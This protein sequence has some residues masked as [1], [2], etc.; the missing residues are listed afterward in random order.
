[1][2]ELILKSKDWNDFKTRVSKL[3]NTKQIGDAFEI[4]IK[5]YLISSPTYNT[6]LKNVW[7][8][9]EVPTKTH[10]LLELKDIDLGIDLIAET[11]DDE[12][13]SVQAK[14][15]T[16]ETSSL[17]YRE[18]STFS[19]FSFN[20]CKN[21]SFGLVCTTTERLSKHLKGIDKISFLASD[22]WRNLNIEDF[23]LIKSH[24]QHKEIKLKP[25]KPRKHQKKAIKNAISHFNKDEQSRG[26]MIMPCASGKSLTSYWVRDKLGS[27]RTIIAVPSLS[28]MSQTID[29]WAREN[30]AN[31]KNIKWLAVASDETVAEAKKD[32]LAFFL[33]DFG[34]PVKTDIEYITDWLTKHKD[35][36][37]VV[38]TTYQSG[39][40]IAQASKNASISYDLGIMDEAHKTVGQKDKLFSYLLFDKNIQID[41]RLFM[42]ATERRYAGKQ[43]KILSMEDIDVY[44]DTFELL[45]FK[46]AVEYREPEI[47]CDYKVITIVVDQSEI[48]ELIQN[49]V[50]VE[51]DKLNFNKEIE[52]EMLA[53]A[54]A[55]RKAMKKHPI[56]HAVTFHGSIKKAEFFKDLQDSLS[57]NSKDFVKLETFHVNGKMNTS[58][59][60]RVLKEFG[61]S[62]Y[63]LITNARCLTE[64]I[65]VP[66]IDCILFADPK[67]S[68]VDIVQAVGR[69][70]R[71]AE[72][73]KYGYVVI[74]LLNR[75][76][77][78]EDTAFDDILMILRALASNDERIVEYFRAKFNKKRHTGGG[79]VEI[80]IDER[81]AQKIDIDKFMEAIETKCWKRL[82]KL[83]WRPFEEAREFVHSLKLQ[84]NSQWLKYC[85]GGK[86]PLDIPIKPRVTYRNDG[87]I[88]MGDWL[89][90]GRIAD[91]YKEYIPFFQSR[92]FVHT[93]NLKSESEWREY[94]KSGKKPDNIPAKPYRTYK[95]NWISMGDWLGT[96]RIADQYKSKL[97]L[98]YE[99]AKII[100]HSLKLKNQFDWESFCKTSDFPYNIPKSPAN[101]YKNSGWK[102]FGDWLGTGRI[103]TQN[104]KYLS[105][106]KAKKFVHK[107]GLKSSSEWRK[108]S[109]G[110]LNITKPPNIPSSPIKVYKNEWISWSDW[111]GHNFI[112]TFKR[113]YLSF[114]EA[115]IVVNELNL[116]NV[117]EWRQYCKSN[118]K[119]NHIPSAPHYS[120]KND[121]WV[122]WGD[123]LGI[124]RVA[125][126]L[127]EW[128]PFEKARE[129]VRNLNLRNQDEWR[130]YKKS[131]DLPSNIPKNPRRTYKDDWISM[132]DWL[133]TGRIATQN[134]KYLS[135]DKAK[136]FVH[137]LKLK[138][139]KEWQHYCKHGNKP[140]NIPSGP[141]RVYRK[142]WISW[143]DWLG[144][145]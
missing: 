92:S 125:N 117:D 132:G 35:E 49:N 12:Y 101:Y 119:P 3:P 124:E 145:E 116:Q 44:G 95:N 100:I 64:G 25:L 115:K 28:L 114:E 110:L 140:K 30:V 61:D 103:A 70:M 91:Q 18:L 4:L 10:K 118:K 14:Y 83:S 43:E 46:E 39:R 112:A 59:R 142:E 33:H 67:K 37:F 16:D 7:L 34:I 50:F 6:Q 97:F 36:E 54:I 121:G 52:A 111:L 72:G 96:G 123:W 47:L 81:I 90:T 79:S 122:S 38:F 129:Y 9:K 75:G 5:Y 104:R 109:K 58:S 93:L 143:P 55:L 23:K 11:H 66:D 77:D 13:W 136:K 128:M 45:S 17:T 63:S 19:D 8:L 144:I 85:K 78:F 107:L 89:G 60:D 105:F 82:A 84:S 42:T 48:E 56:N 141:A 126:K 74:P 113:E 15:R 1:M 73:K 106:D 68:T 26:K 120:Y 131:G 29:V 40:V 135:F 76:E 51:S 22:V 137:L 2:E 133:G 88:S 71:P 138:S 134:R 102:G 20:R 108:Y 65:D 130:K 139:L 41:K 57:S 80:D 127:K 24:I 99:E 98:T 27:K 53:S 94:C 31:N 21:I 32:E 69:A 87:W 62:D 86:K